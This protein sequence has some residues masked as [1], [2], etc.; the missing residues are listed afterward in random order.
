MQYVLRFF[1]AL[2]AC[3]FLI[4]TAQAANPAGERRLALVIGNAAYDRNPLENPIN[5]AR[6]M[7]DA[8]GKLGFR[9]R[10][11]ENASLRQMDEAVRDFGED[12]AKGGAGLFFYAG[13][14]MQVKGSNYLIPIGELPKD[15]DDVPYK[16]F[17]ADMLLDRMETAG[18]PINIVILDACRDNP[19]VKRKSRSVGGGLAQMN[20]GKGTLIAFA[21][22]PGKTAS[23]GSGNNGLF[24]EH[25]LRTVKQPGLKVEDVF[26]RVRAGVEKDSGG[27]QIPWENTSLT[28][29]FYFINPEPGQQ[30]VMQTTDEATIELEYW[31]SVKASND[32]ADLAAYLKKYPKGRFA[33]L[34]DNRMRSLGGT[35]IQG[36]AATGSTASN[37]P[38]QLASYQ[39]PKPVTQTRTAGKTFSFSDPDNDDQER[40]D[41][42][43][44]M[45]S[46]PCKDTLRNKRILLTFS[47]KG[48]DGVQAAQGYGAAYAGIQKRL[49][50]L[51]LRVVRD[52]SADFILKGLIESRTGV[53]PILRINEVRVKIGFSLARANG[54]LVT[55]VSASGQSYAGSDVEGIAADLVEE[56][57]DEVVAKIYK[58]Y[59]S[60]I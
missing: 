10:K 54:N 29:D 51:G 5:D 7:A 33:D 32:P 24:T 4:G 57:A 38:T 9:V 12:L 20:A 15:E 59:C 39:P 48:A 44:A 1:W 22:A 17:N 46:T 60:Q 3:F 40:A 43:S 52:G 2:L 49:Q 23:D 27:A 53:N 14:G 26:K 6:A 30:A 35:S 11:L 16:A 36:K 45:K 34:A 56:Q 8:L 31:N 47:K 41:R 28:G 42:I 19:F 13:H 21:T 58:E 37:Q 18:N 55:T 50:G 25:F